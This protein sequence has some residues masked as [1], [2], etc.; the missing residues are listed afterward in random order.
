MV[1]P[2]KKYENLFDDEDLNRWYRG[3]SASSVITADTYLRRLRNFCNSVGKLPGEL[4]LM[5]E[6]I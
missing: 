2:K 4:I 5:P 6:K 3:L 1:S